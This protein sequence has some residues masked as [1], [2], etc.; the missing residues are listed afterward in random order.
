MGADA[1][2]AINVLMDLTTA[3]V[4]KG[5]NAPAMELRVDAVKALGKIATTSDTKVVDK[6]T[7][8]DEDKDKK[9][10]RMLKAAIK[11]SL[12]QIKSRS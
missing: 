2:P 11:A 9:L 7:E 8:M 6:L 3:K 4:P 12:K 5:K 10:D 1:K